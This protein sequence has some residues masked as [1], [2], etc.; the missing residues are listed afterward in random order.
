MED[1]SWWQLTNLGSVGTERFWSC[2]N[3]TLGKTK[4]YLF[5]LRRCQLGTAK[6]TGIENRSRVAHQQG[7]P[8]AL[9]R[10]LGPDGPAGAATGGVR[11]EEACPLAQP[12]VESVRTSSLFTG[13]E[14]CGSRTKK[15]S[16]EF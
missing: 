1:A 14:C 15:A 10:H 5:C 12:L 16:D 8:L 11:T 9:Y 13:R 6:R 3:R 7:H 2:R 4:P